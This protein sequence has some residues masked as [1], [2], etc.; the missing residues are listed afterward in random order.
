MVVNWIDKLGDWNPQLLREVK[1]RLKFLHV[2]I[3][4]AIS[5]FSQFLLFLFQFSSIPNAKYS[6][7][8]DYCNL[9]SSY[10][11]QRVLLEEQYHQLQN[12][13]FLYSESTD[14]DTGKLQELRNQISQV[15]GKIDEIN[16][17]FSQ[18][19]CPLNAIDLQ[20]WWQDHYGYLFL[21]LSI[22]LVFVL[23]VA[24]TYLLSQDL[25]K[26]DRRGTLTFIRLS[27]QTAFSF[28]TGKLLGVPILIYLL[29]A[30]AIPLHFWSGLAAAIPLS[31]ILSFWAVLIASSIFFYSASLLI[32]LCGSWLSGFQAWFGSGLLLLFL[33][34]T[35][36]VSYL[37]N[38][39]SNYV[40][41]WLMLL[42]PCSS[43][44][45]FFPK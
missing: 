19:F 2:G 44:V 23:L 12:Q 41:S 10:E 7:Y 5:V 8:G 29:V 37:S 9:R 40:I 42:S 16:G 24:G 17:S 11:Q 20:R 1:G 38:N 14:F 21:T 27:P 13:F 45:H 39:Y 32:G 26:E 6:F 36:H 18:A 33:I 34:V 30:T 35:M 22:T 3:A 31:D 4:I 28:F 15:Q 43:V 25:A